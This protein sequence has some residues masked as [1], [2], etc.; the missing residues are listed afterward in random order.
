MEKELIITCEFSAFLYA[1][2]GG[3]EEI[4]E[5]FKAVKDGLIGRNCLGEIADETLK[6]FYHKQV[7]IHITRESYH[8][9]YSVA[10]VL[11]KSNGTLDIYES[12]IECLQNLISD[13]AEATFK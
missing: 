7:E 4:E 8:G 1:Y 13:I 11:T 3:A 6:E 5:Q 12:D 9:F 2:C 10:V